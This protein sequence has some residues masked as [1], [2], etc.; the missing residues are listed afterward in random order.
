MSTGLR[1]RYF[2]A[3]DPKALKG[4]TVITPVFQD[5]KDGKARTISFFAKRARG[6]MAR[7]VVTQRLTD[8]ARLQQAS[9]MDYTF[10][11]A[12]STASRWVFR[13]PQPPPVS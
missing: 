6:A 8:P 4:C 12:A 1:P 9:I 7:H 10:D 13:R 2:K 11:D 5:G 3:V